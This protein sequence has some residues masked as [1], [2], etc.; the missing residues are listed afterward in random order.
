MQHRFNALLAYHV[1]QATRSG[2]I[3]DNDRKVPAVLEV[4]LP[5]L[6]RLDA[7]HKG[8]EDFYR[9]V[10]DGYGY[11]WWTEKKTASLANWTLP[12]QITCFPTRAFMTRMMMAKT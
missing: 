1:N 11:E 9:N 7:V 10:A 6:S 8:I 4:D 5:D 12:R 2:K 3:A